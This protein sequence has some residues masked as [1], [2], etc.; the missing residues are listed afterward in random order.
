MSKARLADLIKNRIDL[1]SVM[2]H[3]GTHFDRMGNALC[4]FH[5]DNHP[6]LSIKN[7]RYKCWACGASGD[8]FDFIQNLYGDTFTEAIERINKD[9]GLCINTNLKS[10]KNNKA[11]ATAQRQKLAREELKR[12]RRAKVLKLTEK[13]RIAY[14]NGDYEEAARLEEVL[15]DIVAYEDELARQRAASRGGAR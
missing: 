7:E 15:D 13:H 6:S 11:I 2:E 9:F 12:A 14:Q 8:M 5:S 10:P 4:P 1:Q 3:Y